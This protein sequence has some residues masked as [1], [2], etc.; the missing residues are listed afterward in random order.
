M[1]GESERRHSVDAKRLR[2]ILGNREAEDLPRA[3]RRDG[4]WN[5]I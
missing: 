5:L 3:K 1:T 4:M 2:K